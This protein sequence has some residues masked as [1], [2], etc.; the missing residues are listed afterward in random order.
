MSSVPQPDNVPNF[1]GPTTGSGA[2]AQAP[3]HFRRAGLSALLLV[4]PPL[5][6]PG[7]GRA[8]GANRIERLPGATASLGDGSVSSYADIDANE[9][10]TA[11]GL[12][13]SA[14]AL[15]TLPTEHSDGHRCF[16]ADGN[17]TIDPH[18]ECSAWHER[19]IPLPTPLSRRSDMPF[20]WVLLNWNRHGHMPPGVWD[21]PH[22]DVHFY[23]EPIENIF[24]LER[25]PCGPE[26]L[27][28]DQFALATKPLPPN[29]IPPDF[30]NVDAAAPAMGNHL[31]D[32]SAPEFHGHGF[33]RSW[34]YGA[35]AGRIIFY[36]EMLARA[37][38]LSKPNACVPIK[39]PAA[40]AVAGYYPRCSCIRFD[41]SADVYTVSLEDF[42]FRQAAPPAPIED[43]K[44]RS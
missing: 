22:F 31:I 44:D 26:H 19:V 11:I 39:S 43:G 30:V 6:F 25:G 20:K 17:G 13:F 9:V 38:L 8:L 41:A 24:A 1:P 21:L 28:C 32:P 2:P 29:Y 7:C 14:P 10:P 12:A 40:V 16:D 18:T 3:R 5:L 42:V 23:L 27:R 33:T 37:Y 15:A 4:I 34:V 35:Y 36:E